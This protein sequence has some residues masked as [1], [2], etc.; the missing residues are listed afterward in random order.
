MSAF[1]HSLPCPFCGA[2]ADSHCVTAA[3][4]PTRGGNHRQRWD[5]LR[6]AFRSKEMVYRIKADDERFKLKAGDELICVNYP[7]DAKVT[8]LYRLSDGYDPECNQYL[9]DVEFVRWHE[10]TAD[11]AESVIASCKDI[12]VELLPW[13][14]AYVRA[15]MPAPSTT[16]GAHGR[17]P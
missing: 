12:G 3:G 11:P 8:V 15:G 10:P 13:Q 16:P 9:S 7:L 6:S 4:N 14:D 17:K 1:N 5:S 2:A